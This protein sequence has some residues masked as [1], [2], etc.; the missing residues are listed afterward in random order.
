MSHGALATCHMEPLQPFQH[1]SL[2]PCDVSHGAIATCPMEPLQHVPFSPCNMCQ[3]SSQHVPWILAT[4]PMDPRNMS[5]G[6]F[7]APMDFSRRVTWS[8]RNMS[9]GG[10]A[11]HME[12]SLHVPSCHRALAALA[13]CLIKPLLYISQSTSMEPSQHV[14]WSPR[15]MSHGALVTCHIE[16]VTWSPPNMSCRVNPHVAT[17]AIWRLINTLRVKKY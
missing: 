6:H 3:G 1:V 12:P 11:C 15:N 2:S 8:P 7:A 16:H 4:C 5:Y 13:T 10:L 14:T 9:H 17:T